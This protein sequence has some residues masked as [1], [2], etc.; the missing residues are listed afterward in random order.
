MALILFGNSAGGG[1]EGFNFINA[2]FSEIM[3]N[4]VCLCK[5]LIRADGTWEIGCLLYVMASGDMKL[6]SRRL[7]EFFLAMWAFKWEFAF[8]T[9]KMVM[10]G[11]LLLFSLSA[12]MAN[13][14]TGCIF[15][16]FIDHLDIIEDMGRG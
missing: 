6:E 10:H 12:D 4:S 13:I 14:F 5:G 8:M 1:P 11:V 15:C 7:Y 16:I 2:V 3:D 9:F